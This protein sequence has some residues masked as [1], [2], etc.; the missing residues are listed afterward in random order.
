MHARRAARP[1]TGSAPPAR[2]ADAGPGTDFH[3]VAA[4]ARL[5][6]AAA[7]ST[8]RMHGAAARMRRR[9]ARPVSAR[10]AHGASGIGMT[11]QRTRARM[12]ERLRERGHPRR[13][14]ARGDGRGAAPPVR[15]G[16]AGEPRLRGHRAADRLRA[17]HLAA[18]R[19]GAHDRG[20]DRQERKPGKV[21]E[22]GTGCGYQAAVLAQRWP[23]GVLD[24]A[25]PARC[26][27]ARARNLRALRLS[28]LRLAHG[29]GNA[30]LEKAAPFR[31]DRRRRGGARVA[32][33]PLTAARARWQNGTAA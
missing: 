20:A 19:G 23:R 2:A 27:S 21:L 5:G 7:A 4:T 6:D 25:H 24:R 22:V 16:G 30:G 32:A 33:G 1:P 9:V 17:D 14:R 12:V 11:S 10:G 13:A 26:S 15:R 3:A 28:N 29:D 18:V 8:S 31:L